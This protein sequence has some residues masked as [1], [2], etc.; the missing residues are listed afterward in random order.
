MKYSPDKELNTIGFICPLPIIETSKMIK[1]IEVGMILGIKSDDLAILL[2]MPA[3][4]IS[5]GHEY[6]GEE[7]LTETKGYIV[8][9][10]KGSRSN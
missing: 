8:Y 1:N 4:C 10:K 7:E 2:D 9:V 6:L 3:W 5:N